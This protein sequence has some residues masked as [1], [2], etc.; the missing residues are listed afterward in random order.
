MYRKAARSLDL[1]DDRGQLLF[2]RLIEVDGH[3]LDELRQLGH[4]CLAV[5][6][7]PS[8]AAKV[9]CSSGGRALSE[10]KPFSGEGLA[11]P[12][13]PQKQLRHWSAAPGG[14]VCKLTL[15]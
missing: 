14:A 8:T 4:E 10:F 6:R 11:L 7:E 5:Y 12:A 15:R 3:V 13:M 1:R 9:G 2:D